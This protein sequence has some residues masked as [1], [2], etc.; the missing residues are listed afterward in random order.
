MSQD[1]ATVSRLRAI[2]QA[3]EDQAGVVAP[4]SLARDPS[5]ESQLR[6]IEDALPAALATIVTAGGPRTLAF[7]VQD[8]ENARTH[9]GR[10]TKS[11]AVW[12]NTSS[13]T[14]TL[15]RVQAVSDADDYAFS[16]F[17]SASATDFSTASDVLLAAVTCSDDGTSA[18]TADIASTATVESGAWIIWEHT[19]GTAETLSVMIQGSFA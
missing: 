6:R 10:G 16:L 14:F 4:A 15:S 3:L 5:I 12:K 9:A 7:V 17:K 8:P 13:L 2:A 19:S 11:F 18:F 1:N